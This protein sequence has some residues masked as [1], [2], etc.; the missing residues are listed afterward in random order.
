MKPKIGSMTKSGMENKKKSIKTFSRQKKSNLK[1]QIP[2]KNLKI[3]SAQIVL[4]FD[5]PGFQPMGMNVARSEF[6][7]LD[8][9]ESHPGNICGSVATRLLWNQNNSL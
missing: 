8:D 1:I 7:Y 6:E 3:K 5:F 2:A 9:L 4:K